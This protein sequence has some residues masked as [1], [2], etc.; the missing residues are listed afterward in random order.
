LATRSILDC[1]DLEDDLARADRSRGGNQLRR[2]LRWTASGALSVAERRLHTLLHQAGLTGWTAN[3]SVPLD[4]RAV[5]VVDVLFPRA[6]VVIEVD[7]YAAHSDRQA[8]QRDRA[9]QNDLV[10]AGYTVLRFTW[11]DIELRPGDVVRRIR[12]A[13]TAGVGK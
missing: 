10:A 8:F 2:I 5:A 4:G 6:A 9:R 3:A 13:V 12:A 11:H 7:G 1:N